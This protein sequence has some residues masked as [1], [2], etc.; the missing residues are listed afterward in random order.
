MNPQR[1]AIAGLGVRH[2][3]FWL[4]AANAVGVWL[5]ALLLWPGLGD[6]TTPL[7]YGRWMP[8]HLNWQLY[9]WCALPLVALLLHWYLD[10][11]HPQA[12]GQARMALAAWTAALVVGGASWLA[13]RTSG[14]L[15]LDWRG[16]AR[17]LLPAAMLGL[18]TILAAHT[19]WRRSMLERA[20]LVLR[21]GLLVV[22]LAVPPALYLAAGREYYPAVNPDSGGA[23]GTALLGS[24]LGIVTLFGL[25]PVMLG[26][27]RAAPAGWFWAALAVSWGIFAAMK[28]GNVS[29][30]LPGQI[31]GLGLL[32]AWVPLLI[33]YWARY[34]WPA[35]AQM[36]LRAAFA[37]WLLLVL[38]GWMTFLPGWSER[39]K[40]TNGLVAHAHLAMA[41]LVTSVNALILLQL[42]GRLGGRGAFWLWQAGCALQVV[43]LLALGWVESEQAGA[44]F[45]GETWTQW[46]YAGRLAAG[47]GMAA[48]S[49]LWLREAW[50]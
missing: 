26:R 42:G 44:L 47:T 45:R 9:G 41:G 2:S 32:L 23:T 5:A 25:L 18:W 10:D 38:S 34:D 4:V 37:W 12:V 22:L 40:F 30:H 24:T 46:F 31:L 35:G 29:H 43:L 17:G 1:T 39:W 11:A 7:S 8:L 50:R 14:K 16:P 21:V 49:L 19:W 36:W 33:A 48:A 15:F 13:G 27:R 3:L 20:G 6:M 28:H